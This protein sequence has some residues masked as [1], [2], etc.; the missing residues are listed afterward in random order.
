MSKQA[1]AVALGEQQSRLVYI[2]LA[3]LLGLL[4]VHNFYAG[5]GGRG[6]VQLL[7]TIFLGWLGIGILINAVWILIEIIAQDVS[8][9]G[10][11][12]K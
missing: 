10:V 5:F 8:A 7:I 4:G 2:I 9:N 1:H 11:K 3:L 6:A 12:M